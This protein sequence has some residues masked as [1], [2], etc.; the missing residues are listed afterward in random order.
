[1]T[2]AKLTMMQGYLICTTLQS[3]KVVEKHMQKYKKNTE[4]NIKPVEKQK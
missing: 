4:N 1:M 2:F 3:I